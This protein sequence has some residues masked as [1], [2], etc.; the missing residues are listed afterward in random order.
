M[1]VLAKAN[2]VIISMRGRKSI[3]VFIAVWHIIFQSI[4]IIHPVSD[5]LG[6]LLCRQVFFSFIFRPWAMRICIILSSTWIVFGD[7]FN[8]KLMKTGRMWVKKRI[9]RVGDFFFYFGERL[10]LRKNRRCP[11]SVLTNP[12]QKKIA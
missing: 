1:G 3:W 2:R 12:C 7:N 5:K 8:W 4:L 9:T 10:F 6:F 11:F